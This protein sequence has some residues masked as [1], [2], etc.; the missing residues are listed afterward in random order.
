MHLVTHSASTF[1]QLFY[2]ASALILALSEGTG[3]GD[4]HSLD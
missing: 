4:Q 2:L 3:L 1:T